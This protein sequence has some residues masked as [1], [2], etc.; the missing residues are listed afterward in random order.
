M[1]KPAFASPVAARA[2]AIKMGAPAPA[3]TIVK[4]T[5]KIALKNHVYEDGRLSL[6]M[7]W[8]VYYNNLKDSLKCA[9]SDLDVDVLFDTFF[10]E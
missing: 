9:N 4:I 3:A 5:Y 1:N 2:K 8:E 6:G 7:G 10:R